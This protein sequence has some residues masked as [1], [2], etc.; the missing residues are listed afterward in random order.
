MSKSTT[1]PEIPVAVPQGGCTAEVS[2]PYA[3]R[4][5]GDSMEPEF[6]HGH[7]IIVDPGHALVNGAY[8]VIDYGG[9]VMFGRYEATRQGPWLRYLHPDHDDVELVPPFEVK[10]V[11]IQRVGRRRK[12][13]KHYDYGS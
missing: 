3:L 6:S 13:R 9:E 1:R 10:G 7:I 12:D 5:I 2:E 4:V 8:A 11:I